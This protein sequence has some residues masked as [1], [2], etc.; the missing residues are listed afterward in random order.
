MPD[1]VL[2]PVL[3]RTPSGPDGTR[4]FPLGRGSQINMVPPEPPGGLLNASITEEEAQAT[5]PIAF[6]DAREAT[7]A[8]TT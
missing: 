2:R 3:M 7:D 6:E 4:G 8:S 1:Q 5:D